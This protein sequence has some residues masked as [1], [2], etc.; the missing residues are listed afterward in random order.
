MTHRHYT[1]NC[2]FRL[3][4]L[5]DK[6]IV[7]SD[8]ELDLETS[9]TKESKLRFFFVNIFSKGKFYDCS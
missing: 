9:Q 3:L 4:T 2:P 7:T 5:Y 6:H 1:S 8:S